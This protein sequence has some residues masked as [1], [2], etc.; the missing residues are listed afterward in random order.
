M[1]TE[2]IASEN[3]LSKQKPTNGNSNKSGSRTKVVL[4]GNP[5]VGKSV[6]F[7]HLS[8]MYVDV[9]NFPG[10]TVS[11]TSAQYKN[12]NI[13]DS[14]GTYGVSAFTEEEKVARDV[15]LSADVV[16]N[17]VNSLH[18]HRD[19]FL[20]LQL[21]EMGKK[22]SVLLNFSDEVKKNK[23][24]IDVEKLSQLLGVEVIET[25]A[26]KKEGF[27]KLDFAIENSRIGN[28]DQKVKELLSDTAKITGSEAEALLIKEGDVEV[29]K[30]HNSDPGTVDDREYLYIQRRNRVNNIVDQVEFENST[31]GIIFSKLGRMTL[32]PFTGIPILAF[33]LLVIYFFV[34]DL[35][36]QRV[37]DY[38][39]NEIGVGIFE[40]NL[41]SLVADYTPSTI[42]VEILG[43]NDD[44]IDSRT[45]EFP[46]GKSENPELAEKFKSFS[47]KDGSVSDFVYENPIATLFFGEFGVLT[48]T[49]TYLLFL[50]LPLVLGFYFI[51]AILEDSGYLPRLATML[52]RTLNRI[53]L[54]G[55]AVIP[56]MLGFGCITMANITTRILGTNRERSIV[57]AILQFVIPCSAQ[58]A[59]IAFLLARA[60]TVPLLIFMVTIFTILLTL[61]TILN[62]LLPGESSPLLLDLPTM[63]IPQLRNVLKKTFFRAYGFMKEAY[64]WFFVGALGIGLMQITNL[65]SV[66]QNLLEPLTTNWLKLPKEAA[67]AFIMGMVRRDFG[68]AGLFDI[69]LSA[70]QITVAIITITIF[71]PCI[72]SFVVML[73]ERGWKEGISIWIGTWI[74]A[75]F[76]GGLV[77]QIII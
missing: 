19:L 10:T 32:N 64:V 43:E 18:L 16:L 33:V 66:W 3:L 72:A 29:A 45:F 54:N 21:I 77:A 41:K 12:Y 56:I 24:K 51:M 60:G 5:N 14:P 62:R 53:G 26:I 23:I 49:I 74:T 52:D 30:R 58:L 47:T 50:L 15:I 22:V 11:I 37:V 35:I 1:K 67:N 36:S 65:L 76:I 63:K 59:V 42:T 48:M 40:Y 34:G 4:A 57:T 17:V 9:S 28:C 44:V 13:Y 61:S 27:D 20:T 31:K 25:S 55:K 7:N 2:T 71:V 69:Q 46:Q 75:F 73:K 70:M 68:A 8:G 39:E 6:F 38:T